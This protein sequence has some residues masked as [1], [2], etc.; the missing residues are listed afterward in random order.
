MQNWSSWGRGWGQDLIEMGGK[1]L[2]REAGFKMR[3]SMIFI[4]FF[5]TSSFCIL[6]EY[7]SKTTQTLIVPT[8]CFYHVTYVL[9]TLRQSQNVD[10]L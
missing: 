5:Y 2:I 3:G 6:M 10:S 9:G 7:I 8:V 4:T 1:G